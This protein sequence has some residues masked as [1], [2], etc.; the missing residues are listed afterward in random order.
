M[1]RRG[2]RARPGRY[3]QDAMRCDC[4]LKQGPR[5]LHM[6]QRPRSHAPAFTLIELLIVIGIITLLIAISVVVGTKVVSSGK[7][8]ATEGIIKA[9]DM[10]L[11]D[12]VDSQGSLPPPY[13]G[14][15]R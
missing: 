5:R 1:L 8:R 9:L 4:G 11:T 6:D 2:T 7:G 3:A 14:D 10:T 15:P 13:V 12:Y